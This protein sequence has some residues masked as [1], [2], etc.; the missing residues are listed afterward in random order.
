MEKKKKKW[1]GEEPKGVTVPRLAHERYEKAQQLK[2][3]RAA[4]KTASSKRSLRV[5]KRIRNAPVLGVCEYCN[6][7]FAADPLR[8]AE[9]QAIIQQQF[10]AH[11]CKREDASQ[12][13]ARIVR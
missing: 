4:A 13:A 9:G 6:M 3:A 2:D 10:N 12:A 8:P 5:V 11:I 7:Q 1:S